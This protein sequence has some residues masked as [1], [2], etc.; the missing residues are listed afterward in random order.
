MNGKNKTSFIELIQQ[1]R[2]NN[3]NLKKGPQYIM[4]YEYGTGKIYYAWPEGILNHRTGQTKKPAIKEMGNH[5]IDICVLPEQEGK[6]HL[7]TKI[8]LSN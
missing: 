6:E 8:I 3:T 2:I 7:N 4:V 5:N 1:P